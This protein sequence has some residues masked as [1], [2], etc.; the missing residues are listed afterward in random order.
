[1]KSSAVCRVGDRVPPL[2]IDP[3]SRATL[4]LFSEA[5][6]DRNPIH[7]DTDVARR[8]G[9]HDVVAHGMLSMAYLGRLLTDWTDP[10]SIRGYRVRFVSV[11][12]VHARP[13]ATGRIVSID[14]VDG[15]RRARL[16]LAVTLEDGTVTLVGDAIVAV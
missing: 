1:M 9:L 13:T 7:L 2:R 11:T 16:E 15:E 6:G 8:I 14:N 10:S 12:P 3:I 4:G 5:S